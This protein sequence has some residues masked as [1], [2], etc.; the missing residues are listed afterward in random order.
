MTSSRY[1]KMRSRK[2]GLPPGSLVHLGEQRP[3]G[4]EIELIQ[5]G[6]E[7]FREERRTA[8]D[9]CLLTA[10]RPPVTWVNVEGLGQLEVLEKLGGCFK[11]HPL[12]LEDIVSTD[13]RPKVDDYGDYL[14]LT[15]KMLTLEAEGASIRSEQVSII[16]GNDF[17][18]S[19]QEG[20]A[21]DVFDQLRERL[22]KGSGRGRALGADYLAYALLDAIVDHYFVILENLAA[23]VERLEDE[24]VVGPTD[25]TLRDIYHLKREVLFLLKSIWPL[26]EVVG[27]LE[28]RG[29]QFFQQTTALY[30]RDL[31][32]HTLQVVDTLEVLRESLVGMLDIYLS[33]MR[34]RL[35]GVMKVLTIIATIFMPLTFIAGV[36]GMNFKHMPELEWPWGYPAVLGIMAAVAGGMVVFFARKRWL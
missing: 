16:L 28:R 31:H 7:E 15:L 21:G 13:Q 22:R 27:G 33:S 19:F 36:Y 12:V 23:Q 3:G 20:L 35:N 17:V 2:A 4:T 26:R 29:T 24:L 32:D 10:G 25:R 8:I 34:N 30:L 18:L 14:Y 5:Y 9:T 1:M 6:A 11:I